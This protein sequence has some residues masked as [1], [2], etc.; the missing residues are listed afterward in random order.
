MQLKMFKF[1]LVSSSHKKFCQQQSHQ[2]AGAVKGSIN[3]F[4]KKTVI[5]V[6]WVEH[7]LTV[8]IKNWENGLYGFQKS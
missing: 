2:R 1:S 4:E 3:I 8:N 5:A 6:N 7:Q